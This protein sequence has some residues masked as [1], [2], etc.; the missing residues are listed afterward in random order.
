[1]KISAGWRL[2]GFVAITLLVPALVGQWSLA[3]RKFDTSPRE[4]LAKEKPEI[5][6]LG[7]SMLETRIDEEVLRRIAGIKFEKMP[8]PG[9]GSASWWLVLKNY[10][11]PQSDPPRTIVIF[12]RNMQ[13]TLADYHTNGRFRPRL[14]ALMSD[15]GEPYLEEILRSSG[16]EENGTLL[17]LVQRLY[18]LQKHQSEWQEKIYARA[19]ILSTVAD[20]RSVVRKRADRLFSTRGLRADAGAYAEG[21]DNMTGL[22]PAGH[23]LQTRLP[24]SLLPALLDLAR[25]KKI[26]L[27][28]FRVKRKPR[29]DGTP[30]SESADL[31]AYMAALRHHLR[32]P[33]QLSSTKP[34][35]RKSGAISMAGMITC[36][37]IAWRTTLGF[38][39]KSTGPR[40][41]LAN[42]AAWMQRDDFSLPGISRFPAGGVAALLAAAAGL[43]EWVAG[44]GELCFL[45]LGSSVVSPAVPGDNPHRLQPRAGH[46]VAA[47][48]LGKNSWSSASSAICRCSVSL[49]IIISSGKTPPQR[50]HLSAGTSRYPC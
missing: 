6:L 29:D 47:A 31:Q 19:L 34:R 49:S 23:D 45:R 12:F 37:R 14:E 13:L 43:A 22:A 5:V 24:D 36:A 20:E 4:K 33:G 16:R 7:D 46:R 11:A 10:I 50:W 28:F 38:S 42:P 1:M 30:R 26:R 15:H 17:S 25:Q 32:P 39:G 2:L 9:S 41:R 3:K 8:Y 35:I 18:P 40:S 48:I 27:V 44:R 21:D